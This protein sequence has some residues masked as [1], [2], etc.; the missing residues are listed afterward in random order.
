MGKNILIHG[1][2]ARSKKFSIAVKAKADE[3]VLNQDG[4]PSR[5]RNDLLVAGLIGPLGR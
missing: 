1:L 5:V 4:Q 2:L 3:A